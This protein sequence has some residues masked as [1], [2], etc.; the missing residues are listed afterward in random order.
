MKR[1]IIRKLQTLG[2]ALVLSSIAH[3]ALAEAP[4]IVG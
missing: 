3:I 4:R 1:R 2:L